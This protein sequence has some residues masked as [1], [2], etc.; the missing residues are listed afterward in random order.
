MK[1]DFKVLLTGGA[2]FIGSHIAERLLADGH[3]VVVLDNLYAGKLQ[4]LKRCSDNPNFRFIKGDIRDKKTVDEAMAGSRC[5]DT[6]SRHHERATFHKEPK[7]C[8]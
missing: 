7:I 5:R 3:S 2:G 8:V 1:R 4:N 6:S